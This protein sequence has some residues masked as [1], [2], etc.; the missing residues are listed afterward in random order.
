MSEEREELYYIDELKNVTPRVPLSSL[1][2]MS[3]NLVQPFCQLLLTS[4]R[5]NI[6]E[7]R[8]TSSI[9][10]TRK[11]LDDLL[12]CSTCVGINSV[13]L[14]YIP[15]SHLYPLNIYLRKYRLFFC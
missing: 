8:Y 2:K 11:G 6:Y 15:G 1:K 13:I 3:P 7:Q 10:L 12:L 5:V 14:S 9:H 4:Q